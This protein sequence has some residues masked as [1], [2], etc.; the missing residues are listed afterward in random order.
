MRGFHCVIGTYDS[1]LWCGYCSPE[2]YGELIKKSTISALKESFQQIELTAADSQRDLSRQSSL[3]VQEKMK[4]TY[5]SSLNV[6]R[7]NGLFGRLRGSMERKSPRVL[8]GVFDTVLKSLLDG[9]DA[10]I[11][12]LVTMVLSTYEDIHKI[13]EN[14]FSIC[15]DGRI[16]TAASKANMQDKIFELLMIQKSTCGMLGIEWEDELHDARH[17][18]SDLS[19]LDQKL[20]REKYEHESDSSYLGCNAR[21]QSKSMHRLI[22]RGSNTHSTDNEEDDEKDDGDGDDNL[23]TS[24]RK[25]IVF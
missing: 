15:W 10:I 4:E 22:D 20:D 5:E 21:T 17:S 14:T 9:I 19:K 18:N 24:A 1:W 6:E 16:D 13:V 7:G 11:K 25:F 23:G 8:P 12:R 3:I 2:E